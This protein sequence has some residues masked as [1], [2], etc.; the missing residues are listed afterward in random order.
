MHR[1][2]HE[3]FSVNCVCI[4]TSLFDLQYAT[5]YCVVPVLIRY[6]VICGYWAD[7]GER[8]G[9]DAVLSI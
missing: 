6:Y 8:V 3:H 1:H 4:Y 5:W 7:Q 9:D 2:K